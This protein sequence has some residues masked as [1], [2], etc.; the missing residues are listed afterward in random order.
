MAK[1][2]I[3][4]G[5]VRTLEQEDRLRR[6]AERLPADGSV[7]LSGSH[8]LLLVVKGAIVKGVKGTLT[9][10]FRPEDVDAAAMVLESLQAQQ[11]L[12]PPLT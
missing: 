11:P 9:Q 2:A 6:A 5:F 3:G 12:T 7:E 8:G 10:S 1:I 4:L